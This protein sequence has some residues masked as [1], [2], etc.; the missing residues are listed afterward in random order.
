M[1]EVAANVAHALAIYAE[2]LASR[3]RVVVIGD[4]SLGLDARLADLG[5]RVIHVY[6]PDAER[7]RANARS[8]AKG[9]V[10][11]ELPPGELDVRQGA[12]DLALVPDLAAV[13]DRA[14]LLARVR[15]LV[16]DDGAAIFAAR[17]STEA[18]RAPGALDYYEMYDL[19]ALQFPNVRMIGQVRF[20]GVAFAELGES[21]EEP[22]VTV[23]TQLVTETEAPELTIALAGQHDVRLEPYAIVQLPAPPAAEAS[24]AV[25]ASSASEHAELAEAVLRANTLQSQLDEQRAV[26]LRLTAEG[27]R[28]NRVDELEAALH[29]RTAK[30]KEAETRAGEHYVRA[31]RLAHDTRR[32]E[33]ELGRAKERA[34]RVA[35][36]LEDERKKRERLEGDLGAARKSPE[37]ALTRERVVLLE[38]GLRAAEEA[39][40]VL[41]QRA[42]QA[43]QI[44]AQRDA[45]LTALATRAASAEAR[46][47]LLDAQLA[48]AGDEVGAELAR[49]ESTLR[50]RAQTIAALDR[51][52]ARREG[53]VRE[54]L[55]ALE[56]AGGASPVLHASPADDETR[57]HL[58]RAMAENANLRARLDGLA[59]EVARREAELQ[60]RGWRI[61]ALEERVASLESAPKPAHPPSKAPVAELHALQQALA[62]EHEARVRA[63]SGE[64]LAR[65]RADLA[66][67][68]VLLEQLSGELEAR[69]RAAARESGQEADPAQP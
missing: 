28:A 12:F 49:L 37:I 31:E 46:A 27:E 67:Q 34:T 30:L 6:D 19:V 21:D 16:G 38:E 15:R 20:G 13:P 65:A 42:L 41:Q 40:D 1:P 14:G 18:E 59:L 25:A 3:R 52:V 69:D 2:S 10:I 23:D 55:L 66:R 57:A 7:A 68:A 26:A 8:A 33:E 64:E 43:D 63:E 45:Q 32:L 58:E 11:R 53:I 4:S 44:I 39:A 61:A 48:E 17:T 50:E 47:S 35:K 24:T 9:A 56:E 54:L 62:Q 60:A 36:E 5:A 29:E 51:E 22:A